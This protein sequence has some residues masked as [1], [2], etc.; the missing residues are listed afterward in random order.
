[1][2]VRDLKQALQR[3]YV[4]PKQL[5]VSQSG[6]FLS[7][8][9]ED[10]R[11]AILRLCA[12]ATVCW[13]PKTENDSTVTFSF[14]EATRAS[15]LVSNFEY[16]RIGQILPFYVFIINQNFTIIMSDFDDAL[17]GDEAPPMEEKDYTLIFCRRKRTRE[18]GGD[19]VKE[20]L[21][22]MKKRVSSLVPP[23]RPSGI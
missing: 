3:N 14:G 4:M 13:Q 1:M 20:V 19:E 5:S 11:D 16:C 21:L 12:H 15:L 6:E 10:R 7:Y 9:E 22:G 18:E 2:N 23:F 17:M 8:V